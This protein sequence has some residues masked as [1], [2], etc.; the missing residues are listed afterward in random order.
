MHPVFEQIAVIGSAVLGVALIAVLVGQRANTSGVL[1]S[2]G[3][4]MAAMINAATAPVT[5]GGGGGGGSGSAG[6]PTVAIA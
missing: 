2:M 1:S 5:G 3:S 6:I 4:S